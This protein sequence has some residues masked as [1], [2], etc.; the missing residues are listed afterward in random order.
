MANRKNLKV[1]NVTHEAVKAEQQENET[2]D[3]TLQRVLGLTP[4]TDNIQQGIAAYLDD[5][6]RDQVEELVSFIRSLGAFEETIG[7]DGGTTG[8]DALSFRSR[9]SGLIIASVECSKLYYSINYRDSGGTMNSIFEVY[10][11]D[12]ADMDDMKERTR[13][14]VEGAL[15]RWGER[16]R[17]VQ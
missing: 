16:D 7:K 10:H 2:I 9:D 13:K 4:S 15:R 5:E 11:A 1:S 12:K 14:H 6:Q 8:G 3:D 17:N